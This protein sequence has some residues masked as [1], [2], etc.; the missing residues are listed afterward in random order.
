MNTKTDKVN[1]PEAYFTAARH[2]KLEMTFLVLSIIGA[3]G[4]AIFYL[5]FLWYFAYICVGI[6]AIGITG[7]FITTSRAVKDAD[8]DDFH[9]KI[10]NALDR[11][12]EGEYVIE[13]YDLGVPQVKV[14][15][16]KQ[17]RSSSYSIA[18]F[19]FKKE[20]F[21]LDWTL[22]DLAA[23]TE[24]EVVRTEKHVELPRGIKCDVSEFEIEAK[25]RAAKGAYIVFCDKNGEELRIPATAFSCDT[26]EITRK[27]S[28]KR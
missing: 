23:S 10:I 28:E 8:Y 5:A 18:V 19:N 15:K 27:I 17:A 9:Q 14:G 2:P 21:T 24:F 1:I 3:A 4:F 11:R 13:K 26:D 12:F 6:A 22:V 20:S 25:P 7:Y 16:D